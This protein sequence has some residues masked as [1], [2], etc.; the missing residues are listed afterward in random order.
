MLP[1]DVTITLANELFMNASRPA[2]SQPDN[3]R[4]ELHNINKTLSNAI[5]VKTKHDV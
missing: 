1:T 4:V 3:V 5:I 2:S